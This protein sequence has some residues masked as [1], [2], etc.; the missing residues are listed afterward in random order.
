MQLS[1]PFMTR[2]HTIVGFSH[3]PPRHESCAV[4]N[5]PLW[6]LFTRMRNSPSE[7][8]Y[9]DWTEHDVV[10]WAYAKIQECEMRGGN[11]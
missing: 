11:V 5:Y 10:Q 2:H 6:S 9:R 4:A 8:M 7:V 1:F 3:N